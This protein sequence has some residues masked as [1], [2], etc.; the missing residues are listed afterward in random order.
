[1]KK[2]IVALALLL[3][4]FNAANVLADEVTVANVELSGSLG[5]YDADDSQ[6]NDY[7]TMFGTGIGINFSDSWAVLL[8]YSALAYD[9]EIGID[10]VP[11]IKYHMTSYHYLPL[12]YDFSLYGVWGIGEEKR[13]ELGETITDTQGHYGVGIRYRVNKNWAI[14]TDVRDFYNFDSNFHEPALTMTLAFRPGKGDGR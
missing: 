4:V 6:V 7:G 2:I 12:G 5:Y 14:R 9:A 8:E 11:A 13:E 10:D 3:P 1:M